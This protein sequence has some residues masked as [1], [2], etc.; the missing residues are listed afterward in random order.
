MN[1]YRSVAIKAMAGRDLRSTLF[2][3][4]IY[5]AIALGLIVASIMLY[6][7]VGGIMENGLDVMPSSETETRYYSER[8]QTPEP[9]L[10]PLQWAVYIGAVYITLSAS[11]S[12]SRERDQGTMEVLFYGPVDS[13]A[14][15]VAKFVEQILAF[16]VIL[17]FYI[18]YFLILSKVS[19]FA[20]GIGFFKMLILSLLLA[21]CM[22]SFGM[23]LSSMTRR[24]KTSVILFLVFII[25]FLTV[26]VLHSYFMVNFPGNVKGV[27]SV[28]RQVTSYLNFLVSWISP[29]SYLQRGTVAILLSSNIE[30]IKSLVFSLLYTAVLLAGSIFIFN[31]KGVRR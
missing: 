23:F 15:V 4:G 18:G 3:M 6:T 20:L 13:I 25:I 28:A 31:K 2:S 22:A 19:N 24:V 10:G 29:F 8:Q 21:G 11:M 30:F 14:F 26:P 12:I 17:L 1:N 7:Y 5:I 16:G 9:M 27:L